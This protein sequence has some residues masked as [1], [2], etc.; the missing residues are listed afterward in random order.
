MSTQL[1]DPAVA[2]ADPRRSP[3]AWRASAADLV[4]RFAMIGVLIA[5]VIAARII[6]SGFLDV[7]NIKNLL[8]NDAPVGLV[9]IGM[10]FVLIGGGFD[11][12][13]GGIFAAAGVLYATLANSMPV[14]VAFML[15]VPIA[16][17]MGLANGLVI[18]R[19]HVNAFVATLGSASIFSGIAFLINTTGSVPV[20]KLSFAYLGSAQWLG[21]PVLIWILAIG[22]ILGALLLSRTVYGRS[23]YIVGGNAE[24]ARL[25]GMRVSAIQASTYALTALAA[26]IAGM[27]LASQTSVGQAN[28]GTNITLDSIAIVIIGGT[29]LR[30]GQGA[31]WRT[32]VGL[33]I[34]ATIDS[35][36]NSMAWNS[37]VQSIAK[38]VIVI[39]AVALDAWTQR[40]RA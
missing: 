20:D 34:I 14:G 32:L 24:A 17:L 22:F 7:G 40:R 29:S 26:A 2:V 23:V 35:V 39:V 12:S 25:A 1:T 30:G 37:S 21:I 16:I 5:L 6:Y 36:F 15:M 18:T 10:T 27:L 3:P 9:A 4:G 13:V 31:M 8:A 33:L 38:G 11:L 19:L 28:V